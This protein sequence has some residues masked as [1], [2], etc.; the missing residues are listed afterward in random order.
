MPSVSIIIA[1][2]NRP[3]LLP[4]A[5][6]SARK[7]SKDAEIIVVDDASIDA[8]AEVCRG[9]Q[10]IRYIRLDQ[11]QGVAGARNVG[12][13]ASSAEY[14][15][16]L[17]DDDIR[18]PKSL[19]LQ[20]GLLDANPEAGLSYGQVI[21]GDRDC[22]PT[23]RIEPAHTPS[24]DIFWDLL[25]RTFIICASVVFR[26]ACLHRVGL[27][28]SQ[29]SGLDD[30]DLWVRLCEL[31]PVVAIEEPVAIWRTATPS[32]FQ[33]SSASADHMLRIVRHQLNLFSLRRV[34]AA[35]ASKRTE[36]RR[37]LL[38]FASDWLIW[39]AAAWLPKGESSYA[40]KNVLT[41]L[42]LNPIRASRPWTFKLLV[43]SFLSGQLNTPQ[44]EDVDQRLGPRNERG[45]DVNA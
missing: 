19:D 16:F 37:R 1:T 24:G 35:S 22:A 17:D 4:R 9:L 6:E 45:F 12:I 32:S 5:V 31:Y 11:N 8:T 30:W 34:E 7:A 28:N 38:N 14:I 3:H 39:E 2:H 25:S 20:L 44:R 10:G 29:L 41:A 33:G 15:S 40:R 26:K 18:L 43:Q 42:Q 23:S 13:L 21:L 36:A 27:L